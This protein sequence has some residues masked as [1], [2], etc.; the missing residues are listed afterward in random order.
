GSPDIAVDMPMVGATFFG[1]DNS[2]AGYMAGAALGEWRQ[3][4]WGGQLDRLIVLEEPRAGALPGSRIQGML[5]G[6][7]AIIGEVPADQRVTLNGG[8]TC[9]MSE[10]Q[11]T[12]ALKCLPHLHRLAVISFN[13]DSAMGALAAA[14]QLQREN[15][16]IIV[17]QGADRRV[18][19][20]LKK[21]DARIVG[22]TAYQPEQY[23][24]KIIPLAL[25]ILRGE[26]VP[27]AVYLEHTFIRAAESGP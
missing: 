20:E 9:E 3:R 6:V 10:A 16:V 1:V 14:R 26:P 12:E 7:H 21:A 5:E 18:R 4:A 11:M 19:E 13:D 8:N 2:R 23:G 22:S 17:G 27:P 25:K 15:D 24:E